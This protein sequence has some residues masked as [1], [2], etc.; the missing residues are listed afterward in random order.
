MNMWYEQFPVTGKSPPPT[1]GQLRFLD[2]FASCPDL[3]KLLNAK[4]EVIY[5][6]S[7]IWHA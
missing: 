7:G 6:S 1:Y 3:D 2:G 4:A 5:I